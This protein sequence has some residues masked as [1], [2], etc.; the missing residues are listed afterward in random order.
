V[1]DLLESLRMLE[2]DLLSL[3]VLEFGMLRECGF[4]EEIL[5]E[6]GF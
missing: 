6:K 5:V 1:E 2:L 3:L 4:V